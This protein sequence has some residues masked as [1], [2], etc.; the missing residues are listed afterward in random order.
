VRF[1]SPGSLNLAASGR[2]DVSVDVERREDSSRRL[3]TIP[4]LL[5]GARI[6]LIPVFVILLLDSDTRVPGFVLLWILVA[7]DWV[8]GFIARRTGQVTELGKV[9]DPLADRLILAAALI[10]LV[11]VDA[12]PLWAA[13]L[14]LIRDALVLAAGIVLGA[15][16][17]RIAVRPIGKYAT[18]TLCWGIA[19]IAWSNFGFVMDD[20][21]AVIGWVWFVVGVIEYYAAT[22]AY[23]GDVR[24]ALRRSD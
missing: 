19:L 9:L 16:G 2:I 13:L 22:V 20:V 1:R 8:D 7:T 11:A 24:Q 14:V 15:R 6:A 18:F 12:I 21:A 5:S 17:I 4:N 3:L 23:V 10:T